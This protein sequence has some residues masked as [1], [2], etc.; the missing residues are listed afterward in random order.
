MGEFFRVSG[1]SIMRISRLLIATAIIGGVVMPTARAQTG[2]TPAAAPT[3]KA[4]TGNNASGAAA[5]MTARTRRGKVPTLGKAPEMPTTKN[6]KA[7][8]RKTASRQKLPPPPPF[9][10]SATSA[11]SLSRKATDLNERFVNDPSGRRD[12]AGHP[13]SFYPSTR[14]LAAAKSQQ[15][16]AK[17]YTPKTHDNPQKSNVQ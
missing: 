6:K 9:V 11:R 5:S 2:S 17:H 3:L 15:S 13:V 8:E 16:A 4:P 1:S 7:A 10:G 14:S 12:L